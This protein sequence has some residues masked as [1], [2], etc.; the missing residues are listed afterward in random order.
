MSIQPIHFHPRNYHEAVAWQE[1]SRDRVKIA[2]LGRTPNLVAGV[3]AAYDKR[4][5]RIFGAAALYAYPD[6]VLLEE[7]GAEDDI[8]F[9]YIPGLLSFREAPILAAALAGLSQAPDVVLVDG[10]GI[11]HP[12]GLG[13]ASHLG[14]LLDI[15]TIGVAKSRLVGEGVDPDGKAGAAS[16]LYREGQVVGLIVRTQDRVRPLYLS[17]GHL[18]TL[19]ECLEITLGCVRRYRLPLPLRQADMLSR[20]LRAKALAQRGVLA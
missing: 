5:K 17:P 6:L 19:E 7:A 10:Q 14:V 3:D 16:P 12:R 15:P 2:P 4:G 1:A 9:P 20:R 18:L 13:L 11:A 8:P